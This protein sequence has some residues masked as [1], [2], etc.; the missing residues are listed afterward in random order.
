MRAV[1]ITG[2]GKRREGE[3]EQHNSATVATAAVA[4]S[5][6][7]WQQ[8]RWLAGPEL[9]NTTVWATRPAKRYSA[10]AHAEHAN[11]TTAHPRGLVTAPGPD[12]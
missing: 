3:R 6:A 9:D 10:C 1:N 4:Q 2:Y 7:A 8:Q 5:A 11:A 12:G